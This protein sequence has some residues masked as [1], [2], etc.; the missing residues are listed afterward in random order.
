MY[1]ERQKIASLIL[2]IAVVGSATNIL[3]PNLPEDI[4]SFNTTLQQFNSYSDLFNYLN[5]SHSQSPNYYG[6]QGGSL[7]RTFSAMEADSGAIKAPD[8][9]TTNIQVEGVDEADIIK[10]DGEYIYL[11]SN[12]LIHI[13][14]AYPSSEA[15]ILATIE[16][17]GTIMGLFI[18]EDKLIVFTQEYPDWR[19]YPETDIWFQAQVRIYN[20][21]DRNEP[22]LEDVFTLDGYYY[23]SRMIGKYVYVVTNH[24]AYIREK[25]IILPTI[26]RNNESEE[27]EATDIYYSDAENYYNSF[28]TIISIN[29]E[30]SEIL[31]ETILVGYSTS[32]YVSQTNIYIATPIYE[33]E[34]QI[35]EIHRIN[36][37][38]GEIIYEAS[39]KVPGYVL[40]QFSM[41]EYNSNFRIATTQGNIGRT[42]TPA[43]TTNNVFVLDEDLTI[44]GRLEELAPNEDIYSA[45]FMGTRCYLVTFKKV[46][47]LFVISLEDPTNP[48]ILGKLKI[49]GYSNYLHPYSNSILIGIGKETV[50][51]EVGDFAWYQGVKISLFD[52]TDV[53]NPIEVSKYIIGD[54]GTDSPVLYDHK[55]LLFSK[56]RNLLV[57][58]V[59]VAEINEEKYQGDIPANAYGDFVW[60]GAYVF[61]ITGNS[62]E[63]RGG[64]THLDDDSD[65]LKSGYYFSSEYSVKRTLYI[66][67]YLYTISDKKIKINNLEDLSE[68]NEIELP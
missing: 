17:N 40:N 47:P 9:S 39:G 27:I 55:A 35:T 43:T 37:N 29:I 48:T 21:E 30:T 26:T 16:L 20:V 31:H 3:L 12:S 28:T 66:D 51:S 4:N 42:F 53:E 67:E 54:R 34:T 56:E 32:L 1:Q 49:P 13:I 23:N 52:A 62:I 6:V 46:D 5:N 63:F 19:Y 8:Y 10:T 68:I 2:L 58:P 14:K 15:G 45:R 24:P 41:D 25:E 57:I 44:I 65:L 61:T 7:V 22:K 11:T 36:I 60:Q 64:I 50:E 59:L 38:N 33:N 18:N